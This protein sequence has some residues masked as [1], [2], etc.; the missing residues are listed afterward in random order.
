MKLLTLGK[1]FESV[2]HF[3]AFAV[4]IAFWVLSAEHKFNPFPYFM[5]CA[6]FWMLGGTLKKMSKVEEN[7][8]K[9]FMGK[10]I[11]DLTPKEK[12]LL[13]LIAL[14]IPLLFLILSS[15]L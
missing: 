6:L 13:I 12:S 15:F 1:V 2:A 9:G 10:N 7:E 3:S 11:N 14:A 8:P 4:A 5:L